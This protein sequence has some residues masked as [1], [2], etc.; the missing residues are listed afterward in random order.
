MAMIED[1]ML[2]SGNARLEPGDLLAV[3][4]DGVPEATTDG[5]KFLGMEVVREIL[6]AGRD[7]PLEETRGKIV[8]AVDNYLAGEPNSDDVTL[9][10]MRRKQDG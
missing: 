1:V 5:D 2:E 3:F 10:L 9:L 7:A 8:S 4:S 6:A